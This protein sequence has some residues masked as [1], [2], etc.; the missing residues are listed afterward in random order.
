[1]DEGTSPSEWGGKRQRAQAGETGA[2]VLGF[3][4]SSLSSIGGGRTMRKDEAMV[5]TLLV[6]CRWG[7]FPDM[8]ALNAHFYRS[9]PIS[10]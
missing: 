2:G 10:Q 1:M 5:I 6:T 9:I 3:L 4:M 7:F 8:M